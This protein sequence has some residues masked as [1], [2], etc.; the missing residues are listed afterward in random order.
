[1]T[2]LSRGTIY[3]LAK[4]G[5]LRI[6]H[7]VGRTLVDGDSL[8]S[9]IQIPTPKSTPKDSFAAGEQ[10]LPAVNKRKLYPI[11]WTRVFERP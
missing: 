11:A 1:M 3:N 5:K 4:A 9:L 6:V 2:G 10:G 8:R 7:V